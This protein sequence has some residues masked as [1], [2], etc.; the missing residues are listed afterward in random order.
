MEEPT[1]VRDRAS[2]L[3]ALCKAAAY[4]RA[5]RPQ[6]VGMKLNDSKQ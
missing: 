6:L 2:V 3:L 4:E 1:G 5:R